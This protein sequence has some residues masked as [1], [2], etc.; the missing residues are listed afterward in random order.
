MF[1]DDSFFI[2]LVSNASMEMFEENSLSKFTGKLMYLLN[3]R[4]ECEVAIN[5]IFYP[6]EYIINTHVVNISFVSLEPNKKKTISNQYTFEYNEGTDIQEI[7]KKINHL[8]IQIYDQ[9]IEKLPF[10]SSPPSFSYSEDSNFRVDLKPGFVSR[11]KNDA[12]IKKYCIYPEFSSND[13]LSVLGFDLLTYRVSLT[14]IDPE[15]NEVVRATSHPNNS[16]K[17][18]L[19]FIYTDIIREHPV[20]DT[21][22]PLL[23]VA[24]L[25]KGSFESVGHITFTN[26]YYYKLR[27]N[28]I[29]TI[30]ILLCDE[31]GKQI[32]FKNGRVFISLHFRKAN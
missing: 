10:E 22:S 27:S 14:L 9:E 11:L 25:S 18:T 6:L 3:L 12:T 19:L 29:E 5:E 13:L 30:N 28:H 31:L 32:N 20:G 17:T 2:D 24:P 15:F 8:M 4:G 21:T 23:R 26:Q 16:L 1:S 7:I